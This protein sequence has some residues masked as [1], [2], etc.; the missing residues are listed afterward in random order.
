MDVERED[1]LRH[2]S[3]TTIRMK[4]R[5]KTIPQ[6]NKAYIF[7][8]DNDS[9]SSSSSDLNEETNLCLMTNDNTMEAK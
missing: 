4:I 9:S 1:M 6:K 3:Q 7:W 2:V 8:N 5:R